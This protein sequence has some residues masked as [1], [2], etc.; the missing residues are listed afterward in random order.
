[1]GVVAEKDLLRPVFEGKLNK[2]AIM[3]MRQ[4]KKPQQTTSPTQCISYVDVSILL[5]S[6]VIYY[7][8]I[9]F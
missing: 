1:M 3:M 5:C 6:Y 2:S 7:S 9:C 4:R 8:I